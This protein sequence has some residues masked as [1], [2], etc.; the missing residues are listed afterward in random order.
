MTRIA[1]ALSAA[2]IGAML[3][4]GAPLAA[5]AQDTGQS[6]QQAQN[7]SKQDL[8]SFAQAAAQVSAIRQQTMPKL[9]QAEN[10]EQATQI[11]QQAGEEMRKAVEDQGLDPQTYNQIGKAAQKNEQLRERIISMMPDQGG[12][13]AN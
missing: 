12:Q 3:A 6:Q 8:Q 4:A 11:Q 9:Q 13:N 10:K 5:S 7:F 1:K 2:G